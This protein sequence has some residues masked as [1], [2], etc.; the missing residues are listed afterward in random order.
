[1]ANF[2]HDSL[3]HDQRVEL[4]TSRVRLPN[5][6]SKPLEIRS[7]PS[8][9]L[10]TKLWFKDDESF[11]LS[12]AVRRRSPA[13][14]RASKEIKTITRARGT[15][16]GEAAP[17][18]TVHTASV[19]FTMD[20]FFLLAAPRQNNASA[21]GAQRQRSSLTAPNNEQIYLP[22][23]NKL[24]WTDLV[25]GRCGGSHCKEADGDI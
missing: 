13:P 21:S 22:S 24:T 8:Q 19:I 16:P 5:N 1:M 15:G 9:I 2:L 18:C 17:R 4:S 7:Q 14:L 6:Q 25:A 10:I 3:N 20:L 23:H 11:G 12:S